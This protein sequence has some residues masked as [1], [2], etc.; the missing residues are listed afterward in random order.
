MWSRSFCA[1]N[2]AI[3]LKTVKERGGK[4]LFEY[5]DSHAV[6][7]DAISLQTGVKCVVTLE[8]PEGNPNLE[9][10]LCKCKPGDSSATD[11]NW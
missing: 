9:Q 8:N 5:S 3:S 1:D 2:C 4:N 7:A 11:E 10:T 6:Y